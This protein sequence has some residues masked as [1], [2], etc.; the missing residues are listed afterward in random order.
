MSELSLNVNFQGNDK[1]SSALEKMGS[2]AEKLQPVGWTRVRNP[3]FKFKK[4]QTVG[5][6]CR[7]TELPCR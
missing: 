4:N 2:A 3:A 7:S 6:Y 5:F 1:L